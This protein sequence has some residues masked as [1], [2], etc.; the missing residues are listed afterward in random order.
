MLRLEE[1]PFELD[2]KTYQLRCNMATLDALEE[3]HDGDFA[4]V[5][6]MPARKGVV[7]ILAAMLNEYAEDQ[8]WPERWTPEAIKRRFSYRYLLDLDVL[9]IFFRA[10]VPQKDDAEAQG[11]V[12]NEHEGN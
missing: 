11:G 9:G 10:V 3:A 5:V 2:G 12:E 1:K 4:E 7:E 6:N 8:G